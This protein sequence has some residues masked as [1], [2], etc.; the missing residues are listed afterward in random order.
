MFL[1]TDHRFP[2]VLVFF[3]LGSSTGSRAPP[4]KCNWS[5]R[6]PRRVELECAQAQEFRVWWSHRSRPPPGWSVCCVRR[7]C[8][9]CNWSAVCSPTV[10]PALSL[11]PFLHFFLTQQLP[12]GSVGCLHAVLELIDT[13][14]ELE[15]VA[16][17]TGTHQHPGRQA[18]GT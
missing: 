10:V 5:M 8:C 16:V 11:L 18:R 7:V 2:L 3:R 17:S 14:I 13:H 1:T 9:G 12:H 4:A 6:V 15:V